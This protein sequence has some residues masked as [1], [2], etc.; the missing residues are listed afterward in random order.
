MTTEELERH[1]KSVYKNDFI[2]TEVKSVFRKR[3]QETMN[4]NG[5]GFADSI[6][7]Y[8]KGQVIFTGER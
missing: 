5:W 2:P 8:E 7:S 1:K 3:R 6:F 4:L